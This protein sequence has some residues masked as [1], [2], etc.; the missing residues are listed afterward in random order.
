MVLAQLAVAH[1]PACHDD[2]AP[3]YYQI[4]TMTSSRS[5]FSPS[6]TARPVR[7]VAPV[8]YYLVY[9]MPPSTRLIFR[10][11]TSYPVTCILHTAAIPL[12]NLV[13]KL[14]HQDNFD[15]L[16]TADG[17]VTFESWKIIKW[18]C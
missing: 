16:P 18:T 11:S 13:L 9:Q 10:C 1:P 14:P 4:D 5:M 2:A 15:F 6:L 17:N 3:S 12:D 7:S 8:I